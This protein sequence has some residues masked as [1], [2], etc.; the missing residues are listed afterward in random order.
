MA[1]LTF[2][3]FHRYDELTE[4]V[5]AWAAAHPG[6]L[7]LESIGES[8]EGR[9]IW[10][11]TVTNFD[12]GPHLEKPAFWI[13]ANIHATEVTGCAAALH[14]IQ[15]L[16]D[17]YG[18]EDRITRV[19]DTRAFYIVPR[20]NPDGAELAL[21]DRPRFLR[22]SVR[23][24]PRSEEQDGLY[25][26]DLDGD[27]RV[28]QMRL[29]DP[30][31]AWK[32]HPDEPRLLVRRE[33]DDGPDEGP[34]YRLLREGSIRNYDG[35]VIKIAPPLEGLDLNRNFPAEWE[36][37]SEQ[38]G[39]GPYPGSEPEIR[40]EIQAIVERPN[41]TGYLS[42]HT[43]SGVHLRPYSSY[44]DERFPTEDLR[45]YQW[46]GEEATK[47]TGYPAI[48]IFHEFKYDPKKTIKGGSDD[49]LYD[50]LGVFAWTTE[51]WAPQREAGIKDYKYI[52]W[53]FD[54]PVDDDLKLL[55][56]SDRKLGGK[57]YI[58]W[59]AFDHPQLGKVELG[60]WDTMFCW[61]NVPPEFLER[62]IA[63]HADLAILH[64]LMSPRLEIRSVD[65]EKVGKQT[66][67]VRLVLMNTGWLPTNVTQKAIERKAVLPLEAE[68]FLPDDARVVGGEKKLDLGQLT[69][70]FDKRNTVFWSQ[71][72]PTTDFAK[73]E[74]VIEAPKG[75][76]VRI[77]ARHPRAGTVR[78]QIEIRGARGE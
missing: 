13:E 68:I 55:K 10:L 42:Y 6:M 41:V 46:I 31:G 58:D 65:I 23:P 11:V 30:N 32:L 59:Y 72:D 75:G 74:W 21:A 73:A 24:Y 51:F 9:Q 63:P 18:K 12:T 2:D 49:W 57:G 50:H 7:A 60:G 15:R 76:T 52:D 28:L 1:K 71:G 33:P 5:E 19:L 39:A 44:P 45:A 35:V 64:L 53:F 38:A 17:G 56:W 69:G 40:A 47:I 48:S 25:A 34:Y 62:E 77:E 43:F 66:H 4:L 14:L 16:L 22:S 78:T 37:E 26:E 3:R 61:S 20:L 36:P 8:Y 67:L 70:R 29:E 27:G 54:H